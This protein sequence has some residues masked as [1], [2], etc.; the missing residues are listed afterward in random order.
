MKLKEVY[1]CHALES[2]YGV[3]KKVTKVL[4]EYAKNT[5]VRSAYP[6]I[7]LYP[8][9][10]GYKLKK[11]LFDSKSYDFHNIVVGAGA[12]EL[13]SLVIS[14]FLQ[15][16]MTA[17]MPSL[18]SYEI[19]NYL[20]M[21]G[22]RLILTPISEDWSPN[23]DVLAETVEQEQARL[24]YIAN[25]SIPIGGFAVRER[26]RS[27]LR[28]I[29]VEKT[30]VVVNEEFTDY[31]GKGYTDMYPLIKE[32]PNLVLIRSFSHAFGLTDLRI[33]YILASEEIAS[34]L[35]V[36][37]MP[38]NVSQLA[39]DCACAALE[40]ISFINNVVYSTNIERNRIREFCT[41]FSLRVIDT[42]TNSVTIPLG[43]RLDRIYHE[44]QNH[45]IFVRELSHF[46]LDELCNITIGRS[47][48]TDRILLCLER[49]LI[50]HYDVDT[51]IINQSHMSSADPAELSTKHTEQVINETASTMLSELEAKQAKASLSPET[52]ATDLNESEFT[53][54]YGQEPDES[55]LKEYFFGQPQDV[56]NAA[57]A[58]PAEEVHAQ[59]EQSHEFPKEEQ[60]DSNL[61]NNI[62]DD[63]ALEKEKSAESSELY[64]E[65]AFDL[66]A[67]IATKSKSQVESKV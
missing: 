26:F 44:L 19:E 41:F 23:F 16:G 1:R 67:A 5:S 6:R 47:N 35:N 37:H 8:D 60:A 14:T 65:D 29:N 57:I 52:E 46:G 48:Q 20:S 30:I 62:A 56:D 13:S 61:Q 34:I 15:A 58:S 25:P 28:K 10:T 40:D 4:N 12:H 66:S 9:T 36:I 50:E 18:S 64:D 42:I 55:E 22:I 7:N 3:S 43:A 32:F 38:F 51:S 24:V 39:Q 63:L 53:E 49:A 17:I 31:L 27:F 45:G 54:E 11:K 59:A 2:P 21:L 33:G